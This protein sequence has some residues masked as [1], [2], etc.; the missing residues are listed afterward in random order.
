MASKLW[1]LIHKDLMIEYRTRQTWTSMLLLC[2]IIAVVFSLQVKLPM[3][4]RTATVS[5]M[6]WLAIIFAS[7]VVVERT[8]IAEHQDGCWDALTQYPVSAST[9]YLAKLIVNLVAILALNCVM[10]PLFVVLTDVPLLLHA[11]A[12]SL[13]IGLGS[14][15]VAAIGTLVSAATFGQRQRGAVLSLLALPLVLPVLLSAS[16][17]TRLAATNDLGNQWWRWVQFLGA[18]TIVFVTLGIVLFGAMIEE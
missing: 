14:L 6:L 13:V 7:Q 4:H 5:T 12:M 18:F 2:V 9:I 15:S 10:V 8:G 17:A 3:E 1:W 16:E 11:G